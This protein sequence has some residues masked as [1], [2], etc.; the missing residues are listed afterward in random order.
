MLFFNYN[1][2]Y[3]LFLMLWLFDFRL[4]ARGGHQLCFLEQ[5]SPAHPGLS[6]PQWASISVGPP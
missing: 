4:Q 1:I 2:I 3:M 5:T 6:Q